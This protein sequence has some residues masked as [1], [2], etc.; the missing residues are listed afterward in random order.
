MYE[1]CIQGWG[2]TQWHLEA[3]VSRHGTIVSVSHEI[4]NSLVRPTGICAWT[5]V[6]PSNSSVMNTL[7]PPHERLCLNSSHCIKYSEGG[8][9]HN[10]S[11]SIIA[12]ITT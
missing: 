4:F 6:T 12:S 10:S 1:H 8:N 3:G 11:P 5:I 7:Q 2:L 9:S